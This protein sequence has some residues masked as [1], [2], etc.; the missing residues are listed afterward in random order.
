MQQY[1]EDEVEH[2]FLDDEDDS[3]DIGAENPKKK[4]NAAETPEA[5]RNLK[6]LLVGILAIAALLT[7]VRGIAPDRFL[8]DFMAVFFIG[9][10]ALKFINIEGFVLAYRGFDV[11]ASRIRPWAYVYPFLEAFLGFWYLLSEAPQNLNILALVITGLGIIGAYAGSKRGSRF[12]HAATKSFI[13][14]PLARLSLIE[15][16]FMFLFALA[17]IIIKTL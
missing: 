8:A 13:V 16:S 1:D 6:L 5:Y 14:L 17:S 9:F 11:V 10:A 3:P 4:S 2:I 7:L 15:N 12:K